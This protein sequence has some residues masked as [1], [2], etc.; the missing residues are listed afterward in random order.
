[1]LFIILIYIYIMGGEFISRP[2]L[3]ILEEI[4]TSHFFHFVLNKENV[5]KMNVLKKI[6]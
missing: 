5:I 1:M 2:H 6:K 4:L 3:K